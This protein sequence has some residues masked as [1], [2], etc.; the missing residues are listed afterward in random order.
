MKWIKR[1]EESRALFITQTGEK[2]LFATFGIK[3]LGV[4]A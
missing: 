3:V 4:P 2:E 1:V